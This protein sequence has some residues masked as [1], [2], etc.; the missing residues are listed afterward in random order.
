M[1]HCRG[2]AERSIPGLL[3]MLKCVTGKNLSPFL[4]TSEP[5]SLFMSYPNFP[6]D[7]H[8]RTSDLC[9]LVGICNWCDLQFPKA[10][11]HPKPGLSRDIP[12]NSTPKHLHKVRH[13][14]CFDLNILRY[15]AHL[16]FT[17]MQF[18][19]AW[20]PSVSD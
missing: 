7:S 17:P 20:C 12:L 9:A 1:D 19:A 4:P 10:H 6:F 3:A 5:P 18:L 8:S 2:S 11:S 15:V 16:L 14:S 13:P